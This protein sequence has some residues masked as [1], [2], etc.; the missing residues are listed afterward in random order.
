MAAPPSGG[1]LLMTS[2]K[3]HNLEADAELG[4]GVKEVRGVDADDAEDVGL[5]IHTKSGGIPKTRVACEEV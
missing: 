4:G 5:A 3:Q 1:S 2:G